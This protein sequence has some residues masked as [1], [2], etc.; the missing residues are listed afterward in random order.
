MR[1]V[2][3]R[4][5]SHQNAH[6]THSRSALA[7]D[8][9]RRRSVAGDPRAHRTG[10]SRRRSR[11]AGGRPLRRAARD[12]R[13]SATGL[14]AAAVVVAV[15]LARGSR[16]ANRRPSV[17]RRSTNL[18]AVAESTH[19]YEEQARFLLNEL[20]LRRALMRPQ[21][22]ASV[23]HDLEVIDG[24]IAELKRAIDRDPR[25]RRLAGAARVVVQAEGRPPQARRK[26][27]V[28]IM[29]Q[30]V[31]VA[32]RRRVD[33]R[34][35]TRH[36]RSAAPGTS[37]SRRVTSVRRAAQDLRRR[38]DRFAS[39]AGI[40]IRSSSWPPR[41]R[42]TSSSCAIR[43]R[44]SRRASTSFGSASRK[45]A[46]SRPRSRCISSSTFRSRAECR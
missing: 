12:S 20:E 6:D 23:D 38:P 33:S 13:G 31:V 11:S 46:P 28:M 36:A 24:A 45:R 22:A 18:T 30:L 44:A 9:R 27:G 42:R 39:S 16:T 4:R 29:R 8:G 34:C 2:R 43:R 15:V 25:N 26:R 1:R 32:A 19:V 10:E 5:R 21:T 35:R 3:R 41:V 7:L 14:A 17:R 40:A 37:C